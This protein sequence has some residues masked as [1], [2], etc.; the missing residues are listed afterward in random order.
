[1][2]TNDVQARAG[3]SEAV[4]SFTAF[5]ART[6]GKRWVLARRSPRLVRAGYEHFLS[7]KR[8]RELWNDWVLSV[9][10]TR[11]TT[12]ELE[13]QAF[14]VLGLDWKTGVPC[15]GILEVRREL[16]RRWLGLSKGARS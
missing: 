5:L 2:S 16:A 12:S 11:A 1:M 15:E 9:D 14:D 13:R 4:E 6:V 10:W 3:V 7:L 8:Y